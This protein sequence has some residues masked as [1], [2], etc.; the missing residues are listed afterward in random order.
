MEGL[1]EIVAAYHQGLSGRVS[2][3]A[4]DMLTLQIQEMLVALVFERQDS[5]WAGFVVNLML[6]REEGR[7]HVC[8]NC[9]V[10]IDDGI[11]EHDAGCRYR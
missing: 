3:E 7:P 4:A 6:A 8:A 10:G 11:E 2:Q 5:E 1:A 9:G